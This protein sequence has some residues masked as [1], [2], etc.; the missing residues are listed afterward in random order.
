VSAAERIVDHV[1]CLG[2]GCAC[3]DIT[4]V[5][6][7]DRVAEARNACALGVA[8]FGDGGVS[9]EV[10]V[11]G[12]STSLKQALVR[13][14][15]ILRAAKRPLVYLAADISCEAQRE[16]V[17][18][19]DRL[20]AM[21]DSLTSAAAASILAAQRRGRAGATLGELRQRADLIVFWGV[22][23]ATSYPRFA[24]RYAVEPRGLQ[25][26]D[27]RRSRRVV[28]VDVGSSRAVADADARLAVAAAD[29]LDALGVL[30][31]T[32][33]GRVASEDARFR[34][35]AELA[36]SMMQARYVAL[37][38]DGE[39]AGPPADLAPDPDRA[40]A[41]VT[42]AQAL[43]G[44]TRCALATLRG[45]GNRS[46]A[47][48][49]TTWQTG[50]P[51]AVDFA[52]GYPTY[53]PHAG[54]AALLAAGE[55]DAALVIGSPASVPAPVVN[56]LA[57]LPVVGIGPRASAAPFQPAVAVDTGVAGIHEAGTAFRMDDVP[58]PLRAALAG[59]HHP[60]TASALHALRQRLGA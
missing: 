55:A 24:S 51:F 2:C 7:Q 36:R 45:G 29:E 39:P 25:A 59:P 53:R 52:P 28:A 47:D 11:D 38:A 54:A 30:R 22:D 17:A 4:L 13:T 40:E 15:Q 20:G 23:P 8:W 58:L 18:I 21:L 26:A 19:S 48:A 1:T 34:A 12:R 41:L 57:R 46:G 14:A 9:Q 27:G 16:A 49:V 3:D 50:F 37:V 32:V 10:R 35:F 5:V 33:Q 56:G 6:K 44:P 42:L 60:T 31:A 43:N